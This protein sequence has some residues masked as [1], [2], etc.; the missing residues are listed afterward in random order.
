MLYPISFCFPTSR[1]LPIRTTNTKEISDI[2]PGEPY[3]FDDQDA[4]LE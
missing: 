3:S 4:Y 2:V 1:I